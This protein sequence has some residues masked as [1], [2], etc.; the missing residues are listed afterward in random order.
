VRSGTGHEESRRQG[1]AMWGLGQQPE[2]RD[3]MW[4]G[5]DHQQR[6]GAGEVLRHGEGVKEVR[7]CLGGAWE[8]QTSAREQ[9][10]ATGARER[11]TGSRTSEL[12]GRQPQ[13]G[14]SRSRY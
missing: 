9:G 14:A 3:A 12:A 10:A 5:V 2:V 7:R 13:E 6:G 4:G 8:D 11:G 1:D